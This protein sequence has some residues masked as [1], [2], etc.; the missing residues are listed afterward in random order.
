MS[1]VAQGG[2]IV[3]DGDHE[4]DMAEHEARLVRHII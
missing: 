2:I 4:I 3:S 1:P